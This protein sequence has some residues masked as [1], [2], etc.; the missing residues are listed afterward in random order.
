MQYS[1]NHALT[2]WKCPDPLPASLQIKLFSC[3]VEAGFPSPAEDHID[4]TLDLN[5][6]LIEHPAA[7]FFVRAAGDS[8][9][10]AGIH[11]GDVLVVDRSRR[12]IH[13]DIVI[14]LVNGEYT[15]KRLE[16]KY[17]GIVLRPENSAYA[18][19][20]LSGLDELV[21]WGVVTGL[22]RQF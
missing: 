10:E 20:R 6:L 11:P 14:A 4:C 21:V 16:M 8:M 5:D 19:I 17:G 1:H 22:A 13:G 18:P 12:A 3:T 2:V 15:V 7:T 9:L